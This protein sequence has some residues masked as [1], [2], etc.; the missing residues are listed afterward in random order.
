MLIRPYPFAFA[1]ILG[2]ALA[3]ASAHAAVDNYDAC[4][5]L[6]ESNPDRGLD[7]AQ[8]WADEGGGVPARHCADLA[9]KQLGR[10][11][12]AAAALD[13]LARDRGAGDAAMRAEILSQAGNTWLLQHDA[14]KAYNSF[15]AALELQPGN[16]D[17]LIDRARAAALGE[18]YNAAA[19]DLDRVLAKAPNDI[20][21]LILRSN[22]RRALGDLP[23]AK[24]DSDLAVAKGAT[25]PDAWIEHGIVRYFLGDKAGA[26]SDWRMAL[27]L[28][29]DTKA[30]L[31][32][33]ALLEREGGAVKP[34]P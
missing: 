16:R 30:G 22:T 12:E 8:A 7:A 14:Q 3:G 27:K 23:G 29:P 32:A 34:T 18:D 13:T 31:D 19:K 9:L 4:L 17:T 33:Q 6:V 28:G 15:S 10:Y 1:L 24:I 2:M 26:Q 20:D 21:A 11:A 5:K 25:V